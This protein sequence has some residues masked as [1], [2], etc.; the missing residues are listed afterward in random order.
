MWKENW[1][2]DKTWA[3]FLAFLDEQDELTFSVQ[4]TGISQLKEFFDVYFHDAVF[5]AEQ[6]NRNSPEEG[7]ALA[8]VVQ[9]QYHPAREK[10][11]ALDT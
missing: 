4:K 2:N 1:S 11:A 6:S 10:G 9:A 8:H 3:E 5:A 7:W